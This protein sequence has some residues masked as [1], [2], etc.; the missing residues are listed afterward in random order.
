MKAKWFRFTFP[1]G[2]HRWIYT[3]DGWS[4]LIGYVVKMPSDDSQ[5]SGTTIRPATVLENFWCCVR[6]LLG[7]ANCEAV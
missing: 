7:S 5:Y 1:N 3:P 6:W 4:G 2:T